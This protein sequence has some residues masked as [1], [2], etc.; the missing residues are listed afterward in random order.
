MSDTPT[1]YLAGPRDDAPYHWR[2]GVQRYEPDVTWINPFE[3]HPDDATGEE[4][5]ERDL[6]AVLESDA[7]L[8]WRKPDVEVCG[9]YIET[10]YAGAHSVPTVVWNQAGGELPEF[11]EWHVTASYADLKEATDAVLALLEDLDS[12]DADYEAEL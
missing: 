9:A 4:I 3:I 1:V 11:L 8:L 10:G 6:E 2:V 5:Y 12:D 7:M